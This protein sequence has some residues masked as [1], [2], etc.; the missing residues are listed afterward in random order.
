MLRQFYI[1]RKLKEMQ[2]IVKEAPL[3]V[4]RAFLSAYRVFLELGR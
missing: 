1:I 3:N 2:V 4:Q